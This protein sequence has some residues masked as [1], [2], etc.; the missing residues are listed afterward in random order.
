MLKNLKIEKFL[1]SAGK[2]K[3][4]IAENKSFRTPPFRQ[5]R[6]HRTDGTADQYN[7]NHVDLE[8][9]GCSKCTDLS[10]IHI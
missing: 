3:I 10:L 1:E 9:A 2:S 8:K 4:E 5:N 7:V 6:P